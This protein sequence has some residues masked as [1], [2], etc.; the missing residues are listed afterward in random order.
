[1][2]LNLSNK[3]IFAGAEVES[4]L[5]QQRETASS[6]PGFHLACPCSSRWPLSVDEWWSLFGMVY[7]NKKRQ[8]QVYTWLVVVDDD[9][10]LR[11]VIRWVVLLKQY[12]LVF[13]QQNIIISSVLIIL[14]F[15]G[16]HHSVSGDVGKAT[17]KG[18]ES[19]PGHTALG[20]SLKDCHKTRTN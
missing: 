15:Q 8:S 18:I 2:L 17:D 4:K 10:F 6:D 3:W 12:I 7:T 11:V 16:L 19:K 13:S 20:I 9:E 5:R 1:M 14:L